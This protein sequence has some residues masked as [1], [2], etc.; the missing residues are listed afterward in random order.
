[1]KTL[2]SACEPSTTA[3][4]RRIFWNKA[5]GLGPSFADEKSNVAKSRLS[6]SLRLEACWT[7]ISGVAIELGQATRPGLRLHSAYTDKMR[8]FLMY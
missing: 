2:K 7:K 6:S 4:Y 8:Q 1:M 3:C 5:G